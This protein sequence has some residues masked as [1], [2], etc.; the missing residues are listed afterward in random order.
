M[1]SNTTLIRKLQRA[2]NSMGC[3][4]LYNTQQFYSNDQNRPVTIY[5]IKKAVYDEES[6]KTRNIE[7]FK[8]TSQIQIVLFLRDLWYEI[9]GMEIPDD[10]E[11]WNKKKQEYYDSKGDNTNG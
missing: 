5:V 6:G 1:A 7:L 8:S 9:N 4:I 11:V 3:N 10:N 2:V